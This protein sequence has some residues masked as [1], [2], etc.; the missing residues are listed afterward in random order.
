ML[1]TAALSFASAFSHFKNFDRAE[2]S[3]PVTGIITAGQFTSFSDSAT[4]ERTNAIKTMQFS[5]N[6]ASVYHNTTDTYLATPFTT[7]Q[8]SDGSTATFPGTAPYLIAFESN[9]S[10]NTITVKA[11]V[12]NP[13]AEDLTLVGETLTLKLYSFIT[14]FRQ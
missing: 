3:I 10:G 9:Y 12:F 2:L 11:N 1:N 7:I 4:L 13:N 5:T 6:V 14:P 8:H